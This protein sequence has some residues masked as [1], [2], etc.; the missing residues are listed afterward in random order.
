VTFLPDCVGPAAV[1]AT[2]SPAP[3]AVFLLE[4]LRFHVE[5]EGKGVDAAGAKFKAD[6]AAVKA[7][8]AD[9]TAHGD[10]YVNDAFGTAHRAHASMVGVALPVRASGFLLAREL[11]YFA[12][13]LDAPARPFVAVLGGAKVADKLALITNLL[14]KV[15]AVVIGGGMAFTFKK[16]LGF[17]VGDSLFDEE[18]AKAVPGIMAKA[19]AL[20]VAIHLPT[21]YVAAD[22]FD[23]AAA[24]R[25]VTDA[26]GVPAGWRGL[27]VGPA[28]AAAFSA[29]VRGAKTVVW[30]GP[31]GVFEMAPFAAGT[32]AMAAAVAECTAAGGVTIVGGGDTATAAEAFGVADRVSHVSTGGGASLE[33]L[34]GKTLPGVAALT[35][36]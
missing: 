17:A 1:A 26:Q 33:L 14:D 2:A 30:N 18:G 7:F 11:A 10:V 29:V 31:P 12:R 35:D 9:L 5:E 25:V 36:A 4:N 34:E 21:D 19:K 16:V 20:G 23:A 3:G 22:K 6:K 15:N 8:A 27:D 32:R 28:T 24:T 13:A